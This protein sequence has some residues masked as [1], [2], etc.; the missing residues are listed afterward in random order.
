[1]LM[2]FGFINEKNTMKKIKKYTRLLLLAFIF[3]SLIFSFASCTNDEALSEVSTDGDGDRPAA[4]AG[5]SDIDRRFEG[6]TAVE[7]EVIHGLRSPVSLIRLVGD[8]GETSED[9]RPRTLQP[10][11]RDQKR[12]PAIRQKGVRGDFTAVAHGSM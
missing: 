12:P 11:P 4:R 7:R 6:V 10:V 1:M 2:P 5:F 3:N 8:L 9:T